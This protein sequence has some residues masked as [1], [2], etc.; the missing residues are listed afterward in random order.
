MYR[1]ESISA[2]LEALGGAAALV[3]AAGVV[4]ACNDA[5]RQL[6]SQP[7]LAGPSLA[8]GATFLERGH[9]SPAGEPLHTISSLVRAALASGAPGRLMSACRVGDEGR[10]FE[11][12]TTC[13]AANAVLIIHRD[14]THVRQA[15]AA[16]RQVLEATLF[17][18]GEPLFRTLAH[19]AATTMGARFG[20]I[21]QVMPGRH[22][23]RALAFWD[24][25]KFVDNVEYPLCGTPCLEVLGHGFQFYADDVHLRFPEDADLVTFGVRAY[26]GVPLVAPDRKA[27]GHLVLMHTSPFSRPIDQRFLEVLATRAAAELHRV[28]SEKELR[29]SRETLALALDGTR[30]GVF[31]WS[32]QTG[33]VNGTERLWEML[34]Y[35]RG[36]L[37][38]LEDWAGIAHPDDLDRVRVAMRAHFR[39]ETPRY[40]V[41]I[42][43]RAKDGRYRWILD[44]G[45]V[46]ERSPEGRALRMTGLHTDITDRKQLE[47][48]VAASARLASVGTLAAGLAHEINTP[49]TYLSTGLDTLA[50]HLPPLIASAPARS[51]RPVVEALEIVREGADRVRQTARDIKAFSRAP[52]E[53]RQTVDVRE[54]VAQALR[55]ARHELVRKA[56]IVEALGEVPEVRGN[57]VRLGQVFLNL[58]IN[59]AQAL[60]EGA[61]QRHEV[62]VSTFCDAEGRAVVE[63]RDTGCGIPEDAAAHVFEPFFTTKAAGEGTGLGLWICHQLVNA[64]GGQITFDTEPGRGTRFCVALPSAR[65]QPVTD[66]SP[67]PRARLLVVDDHAALGNSLKLFLS[68]EHE[69]VTVTSGT[70]ALD[71]LAKQTFDLVLC[72]LVMPDTNGME[73]Y[74]KLRERSEAQAMRVVFMTGGAFTPELQTFVNTTTHLVLEKPFPPEQVLELLRQRTFE[75]T[76]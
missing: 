38:T 60:P 45:T 57:P 63:V 14:V 18:S 67:L 53:E 56:Q 75:A 65:S 19:T 62:R 28:A 25:E 5:W 4:I 47:A 42:R 20:V 48:Q 74:R 59:A 12:Q 17:A 51:A 71:V 50:R 41:E 54:V 21:G 40:A 3:D 26:A 2:P 30:D 16:L 52:D 27:L 13:A 6:D 72:D 76:P 49:L 11:T 61:P 10:W 32:L 24:G 29:D 44:R 23:M 22:R 46:V 64:M 35:T 43:L 9:R 7:P 1:G 39:G 68:Q 15:D 36:E 8:E 33:T 34:G 70:A 31:D 55:L 73:V 69:V 37:Q 66:T 58:L